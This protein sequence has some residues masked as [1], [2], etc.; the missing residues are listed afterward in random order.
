MEMR[1]AAGNRSNRKKWLE[2]KSG[3]WGKVFERKMSN[4]EPTVW[5]S[6]RRGKIEN[7]GQK[8]ER[9]LSTFGKELKEQLKLKGVAPERKKGPQGSI[10]RGPL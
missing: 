4:L 6:S 1:P 2:K 9:I 10:T 7:T 3:R 8:S 5:G